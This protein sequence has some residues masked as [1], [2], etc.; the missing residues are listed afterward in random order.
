MLMVRGVL[1]CLL[2]LGRGGDLTC[3]GWM[4]TCSFALC[5]VVSEFGDGVFCLFICTC[6]WAFGLLHTLNDVFTCGGWTERFSLGVV[7]GHPPAAGFVAPSNSEGL[8]PRPPMQ[9]SAERLGVPLGVACALGACTEARTL[10]W[11][12]VL[13]A[14]AHGLGGSG[15][16]WLS[17]I[18]ALFS[19]SY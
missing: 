13:P 9:V 11:G 6:V 19:L 1:G 16:G 14:D 17:G 2:G 3:G 8:P 15:G 7:T 4:R 12:G 5:S 18:A 10:A